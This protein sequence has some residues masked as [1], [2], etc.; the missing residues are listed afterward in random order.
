[1]MVHGRRDILA[2][3]SKVVEF[4][5]PSKIY[6]SEILAEVMTVTPR[7]ASEWLKCN[8]NNRPVR[9]R[10]I[11]FLAREILSGNWQVNGQAIIIADNDEILDGQHRLF[12]I[13]EA[14][15]SIR[16]MVV[17]GIS[18]EAFKTIDT[19]ALRTGA[20]ALSLHFHDVGP[21]VIKAVSTAVQWVSGLERASLSNKAKMSN[22]DVIEYVKG[23]PS[24]IRCAETI[25]TYPKETR[26]LPVGCGTALLEVFS[27]KNQEAA[28]TFV[29][30]LCTGE[31]LVRTDPE[32]IL[33]AA[34][35]KDATR[36]RKLPASVKMRMVIK[37]WNWIRRGNTSATINTVTVTTNEDPKVRVY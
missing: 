3:K 36:V 19:G 4:S 6:G 28:A 35:I 5:H 10:H 25:F 33:R 22:T 7:D 8:K 13:I 20:D 21:T 34:F 18:K 12:A 15:K 29:K 24:I 9:R 37:G 14:G 26:P 32:F 31:D 17:Y 30:N 1:M 27:R 11:E 2:T 16:T 23:H